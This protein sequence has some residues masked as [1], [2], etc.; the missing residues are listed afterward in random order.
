MTSSGET[1]EININPQTDLLRATLFDNKK[2]AAFWVQIATQYMNDEKISVVP[3][4]V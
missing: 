1:I 3:I 2:L 4:E